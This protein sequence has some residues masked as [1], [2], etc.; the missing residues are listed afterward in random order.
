MSNHINDQIRE[1]ALEASEECTNSM[2]GDQLDRAIESDDLELMQ[3]LTSAAERH[4]LYID[5]IN[6]SEI[7]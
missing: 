2:L 1:R 3:T 4:L 5:T 6:D 7:R